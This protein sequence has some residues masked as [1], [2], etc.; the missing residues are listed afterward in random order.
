[1]GKL[2][3]FWEVIINLTENSIY[4]FLFLKSLILKVCYDK[5]KKY[6][7]LFITVSE[8]I[9]TSFCNFLNITFITTQVLLF[10][11]DLLII[12]LIFQDTLPKKIFTAIL[13]SCISILADKLTYFVGSIL[14]ATSLNSFVFHGS[15][16]LYSTLM[17]LLIC[18]LASILFTWLAKQDIYLTASLCIITYIII[19]LGIICSNLLL[20]TIV[21]NDQN[22]ILGDT[23]AR[24]Q[25]ISAGFIIIFLFLV[26]LIQRIG[27]TYNKNLNLES[28]L[29][30][31]QIN[32]IQLEMSAQS[33]NNIREWKHDYKNHMLTITA[34]AK[35]ESYSELIDYL[36][37]L[38]KNLPES[39]D[40]ISSGNNAIDAVVT[41]KLMLAKSSGIS[42]SHSI[43]LTG[44]CPLSDLDITAIL[45]NLLDNSL[46]A[47]NKLLKHHST[48]SAEIHLK[49][50]PF[51]DMFQIKVINSSDGKY[52]VS[53]DNS[54]Q[55]TKKNSRLHGYGI[56]HVKEIVKK[57]NG[58]IKIQ[59]EP[60]LFKVNI[61]IPFSDRKE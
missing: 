35:K 27:N 33:M 41:N 38:Q 14:F 2:L 20:D 46:E 44:I 10:F 55:T 52:R 7:F 16:R 3:F 56:K 6:V 36:E 51:R 49:I 53:E 42:F 4:T 15:Y 1:M 61:L 13:P 8:A 54:L 17:Y 32:K 9:L 43:I 45:G 58:I 11:A 39:F 25:F 37:K 22:P 57:A 50:K 24:L 23:L 21:E 40:S 12:Y 29:H 31:E 26:F 59:S 60:D 30:Q 19:I 5:H 18:F 34:L 48:L 47:C 28:K